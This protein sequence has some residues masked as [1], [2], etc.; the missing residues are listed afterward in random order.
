MDK[1]ILTLTGVL[2]ENP[3][4][5][6]ELFRGYEEN[7]GDRSQVV[8]MLAFSAKNRGNV[9]LMLLCLLT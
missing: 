1:G 9:I 7:H 8:L 3:T 5:V 4:L 6:L 2:F